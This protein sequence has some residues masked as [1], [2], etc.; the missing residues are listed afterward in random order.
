MRLNRNKFTAWLEAKPATEIVGENRDCHFCPIALFYKEAS[1]GS[2]IIIFDRCGE[3]IIDRGYSQRPLPS[4]ASYFV[5]EV[6]GDT[7]G[8]ISASRALEVLETC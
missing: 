2:E 4:W 3:Y 6:D 5:R 1:G 7:N 8:Q